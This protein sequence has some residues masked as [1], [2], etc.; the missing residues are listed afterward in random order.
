MFCMII[1]IQ[2]IAKSYFNSFWVGKIILLF[3]I[4]LLLFIIIIVYIIIL[5]LLLKIII[6]N[7]IH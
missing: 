5:L 4:Y 1:H 6:F 7:Y 3:I 2:E